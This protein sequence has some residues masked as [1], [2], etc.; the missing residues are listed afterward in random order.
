MTGTWGRGRVTCIY[1]TEVVKEL[2]DGLI[3]R[4][5]KCMKE[6]FSG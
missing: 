2:K 1:R 5:Y 4:E 6:N 3:L